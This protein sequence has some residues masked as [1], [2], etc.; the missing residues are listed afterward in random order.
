MS[1][2]ETEPQNET[3][4]K[5]QLA[6]LVVS[7]NCKE[8]LGVKLTQEQIRRLPEKDVKNFFKRYEASVS[9]KT[10]DAIVDTFI[11]LSCRALA[12]FLPL[13]QN[14]LKKDFTVKREL[15]VI[16]GGMYLRY[17]VYGSRDCCSFDHK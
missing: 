11:Q 13:E 14:N 15:Y 16:A 9:S 10:C 2:L 17:K 7:G 8:M 4:H 3:D 12:Y 1:L 6:I 5:E